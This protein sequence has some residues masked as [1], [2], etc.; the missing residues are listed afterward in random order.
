MKT[1]EFFPL[2]ARE[3]ALALCAPHLRSWSPRCLQPEP[4]THETAELERQLAVLRAVPGS[5]SVSAYNRNKAGQAFDLNK[6]GVKLKLKLDDANPKWINV[7]FNEEQQS[8]LA[9][10]LVARAKVTEIVGQAVVADAEKTVALAFPSAS[11]PP[12]LIEMTEEE[13]EW[14]AAW[15][16]GHLEPADVT[17]EEAAVALTAHRASFAAS[18]AASASAFAVLTEAQL[19]MPLPLRTCPPSCPSLLS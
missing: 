14:L 15:F 6:T 8:L 9:C 19:R 1:G 10:A 16:D 7:H 5:S 12:A 4:E 17:L 3:L 2:F 13:K 18:S 11:L